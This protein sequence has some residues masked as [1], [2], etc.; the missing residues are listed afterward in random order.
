MKIMTWENTLADITKKEWED[1]KTNQQLATEGC[2]LNESTFFIYFLRTLWMLTRRDKYI[3]FQAVDEI[4][5]FVTGYNSDD[6]ISRM[7]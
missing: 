2:A 3:V 1:A 7:W 5:I 6:E 4:I